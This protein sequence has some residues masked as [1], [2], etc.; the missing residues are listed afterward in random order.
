MFE[1]DIERSKLRLVEAVNGYQPGTYLRDIV[2]QAN[3]DYAYKQYFEAEFAWWLYEQQTVRKAN[4]HVNPD[5][6]E[7]AAILRNLDIQYHKNARFDR[8]ELLSIADA[9]VKG[10]L[11]YRVRPRTTLKW[12]VYR[13]EPTKPIYEIYLRMRY[14]ADY[15]YLHEGFN[16]WLVQR[17]LRYDSMDIISVLE[18]ERLIKKIDDDAILDM[19][20]SEFVNLI[21]PIGYCF[22]PDAGESV[23]RGIPIEAVII[24]L[25]DKE[26]YVI[27]QKLEHMLYQQG[28]RYIT[29]DMFLTVVDEVLAEVDNEPYAETPK[30]SAK[31]AAPP[32]APAPAMPTTAMPTT[33]MPTTAMPTP[34]SPAPPQRPAEMRTYDVP[35]SDVR[36]SE[37]I[38]MQPLRE[39]SAEAPIRTSSAPAM[40]AIPMAARVETRVDNK[41]ETRVDN[42]VETREPHE[43]P[44]SAKPT[45][46]HHEDQNSVVDS[47]AYTS[48]V[49]GP[50][51][52]QTTESAQSPQARESA[53]IQAESDAVSVS[54][55]VSV[56]SSENAIENSN[57]SASAHAPSRDYPSVTSLYDARQREVFVRKLCA[58]NEEMFSALTTLI[59]ATTNWKEA[60]AVLDKHYA[61]QG[62]DPQSAPARDLRMIIYRRFITV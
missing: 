58:K 59:D 36:T 38:S 50:A 15:Q 30:A 45:T 13:G 35:A 1:S 61:Q 2:A 17:G 41:V 7:T 5:D 3:V 48:D 42:E 60:L 37:F 33:A 24:F 10:V 14:F 47:S 34:V 31:V 18:F 29:K 55:G 6:P 53:G 12:F 49:A 28:I 57:S 8:E 46:I 32:V 51:D 43:H 11:N 16:R 23:D 27:A 62:I 20:P 40:D 9:A 22:P 54:E 56:N 26:V 25:D 4:P 44:S 52:I 19:S 39:P 21:S